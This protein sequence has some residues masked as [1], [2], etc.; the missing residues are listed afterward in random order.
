MGAVKTASCK[1]PKIYFNTWNQSNPP[2]E[3]GDRVTFTGIYKLYKL[4][5]VEREMLLLLLGM[6]RRQRNL[7]STIQRQSVLQIVLQNVYNRTSPSPRL[8]DESIN[9]I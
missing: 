8:R 4:P 2:P 3:R 1:Y 6:T 9:I 7:F 5:N